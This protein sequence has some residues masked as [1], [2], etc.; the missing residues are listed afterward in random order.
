M[1][2]RGPRLRR[3][4][5]CGP[6]ALANI[7]ANFCGTLEFTPSSFDISI[8]SDDGGTNISDYDDELEKLMSVE[9]CWRTAGFW[10]EPEVVKVKS[11]TGLDRMSLEFAV[12]PT[13]LAND[14]TI[15]PAIVTLD[16]NNGTDGHA[17]TVV[18]VLNDGKGCTVV[19]NTW[20]KQY[21]TPCKKI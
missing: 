13:A 19:H 4:G 15:R 3:D 10:Y 7:M 2:K 12:N 9:D 5:I 1:N 17:T 16:M 14:G 6:V 21:H 11:I 20:G 18:A 8:F